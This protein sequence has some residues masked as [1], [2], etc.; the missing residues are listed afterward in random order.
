MC[1]SAT[2]HKAYQF[3]NQLGLVKFG[4]KF[5]GTGC[6][7]LHANLLF[8][9]LLKNLVSLQNKRF[10]FANCFANPSLKSSKA[11]ALLVHPSLKSASTCSTG[12]SIGGIWIRSI[13]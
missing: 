8:L 4:S 7:D 2:H 13:S 5:C 11:F 9:V 6:F 1:H 3:L 12:G 10:G